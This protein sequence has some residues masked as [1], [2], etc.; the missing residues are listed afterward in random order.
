MESRAP[1][2]R[3]QRSGVDRRQFAYSSYIPERRV[4]QGR[5]NGSDRRVRGDRRNGSDRRRMFQL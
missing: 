2:N 3:D 5:R 4:E 1:D